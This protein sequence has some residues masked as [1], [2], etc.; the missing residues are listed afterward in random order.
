MRFLVLSSCVVS[1]PIAAMA[2]SQSD[3]S[4]SFPDAGPVDAGVEDV[5]HCGAW[6]SA[7]DAY[8]CD[9]VTDGGAGCRSEDDAATYPAGCIGPHSPPDQTD[10]SCKTSCECTISAAAD[11]SV[12]AIWSCAL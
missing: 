8:S 2:C 1:L 11:G 9:P 3:A 4:S 5:S 6:P 10:A 7:G 12:L